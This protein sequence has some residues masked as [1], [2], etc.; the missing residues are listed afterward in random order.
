MPHKKHKKISCPIGEL[1]LVL[2]EGLSDYLNEPELKL[3]QCMLANY[4]MQEMVKETGLNRAT[5][6]EHLIDLGR[7]LASYDLVE[8]K[9]FPEDIPNDQ[10]LQGWLECKKFIRRLIHDEIKWRKTIKNRNS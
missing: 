2:P 7:G 5:I 10:F 9:I 6:M 3:F 4:N 8:C 1:N